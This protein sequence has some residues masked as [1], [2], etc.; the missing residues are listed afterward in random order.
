MP[1]ADDWA[2]QTEVGLLGFLGE[3]LRGKEEGD[4]PCQER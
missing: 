2:G 1:A 3:G 4:P